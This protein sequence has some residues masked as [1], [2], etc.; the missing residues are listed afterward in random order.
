[1]GRA[2]VLS[3]PGVTALAC[4]L[5]SAAA[6]VAQD[7]SDRLREATEI[8][9]RNYLTPDDIP[10][11]LAGAGFALAPGMDAGSF[12]VSAAGVRGIVVPAD[13]YCTFQSP[14]VPLADALAETRALADRLF[15]GMVEDGHP[16]R[17]PSEPCDGMS[18]FPPRGLIWVHFAQ[19]GNSGE[20]VDDGTSAIIMNM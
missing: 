9:L 5:L 19:A 1:M 2:V 11:A 10:D 12:E 16:E 7:A 17:G 18:I 15:P 6:A 14:A 8:C 4:C 20:C 13:R 3:V